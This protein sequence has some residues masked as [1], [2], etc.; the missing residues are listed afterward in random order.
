MTV[1][2]IAALVQAVIAQTTER[3]ILLIVFMFAL[4]EV[5]DRVSAFFRDRSAGSS[6]QQML[7]LAGQ[8]SSQNEKADE[9]YDRT[10][11]ALI[12]SI[13]GVKA[14]SEAVAQSSSAI[15]TAVR[16]LDARTGHLIGQGQRFEAQAMR[17]E[18]AVIKVDALLTSGRT[19][20]AKVVEEKMEPID[21][22]LSQLEAKVDR[23]ERLLERVAAKLGIEVE[24]VEVVAKPESEP[25]SSGTLPEPKP[26]AK[27]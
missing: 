19:S 24:A 17:I 26:E 15:A 20:T 18:A 22:R 21:E 2:D 25:I 5:F 16:A 14:G 6:S 23:V 4:R 7:K 13:D 12:A 27:P 8:L 1:D 9:R 3:M 10:I 11:T